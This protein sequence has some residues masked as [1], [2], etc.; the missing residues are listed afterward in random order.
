MSHVVDGVREYDIA[1][2]GLE[3]VHSAAV[4]VGAGRP[5]KARKQIE[6]NAARLL[7]VAW[8]TELAAR[9]GDQLD[10]PGLRQATLQTLPVQAYYAVFSAARAFT[11]VGGNEVSGHAG[12]HNAYATQHIRRAGLA[13]GTTL[14]GDPK[15]P[16]TCTLTPPICEPTAFNPIQAGHPPAD[17][18][19]A[20]LRMARKW[21]YETRRDSWL[22]DP[23]HRTKRGLPYTRLPAGARAEILG[24]LRCTT[25]LDFMYELRCSTNYRSIDEYSAE[26][27]DEHVVAFHGGL[28]HLMDMGLLT[29]EAQVSLYSGS[30]ALK[31]EYLDWSKRV[32]NVGSWA[33]EAGEA[34]IAAIEAG[35][36]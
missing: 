31:N 27:E 4:R 25:M 26:V 1:T 8:Q 3:S 5:F 21:K 17:L 24:S 36:L 18:V 13:M 30:K 6:P 19:W 33:S 28:L 29:Y 35:G 16:D 15:N 11:I 7:R 22:A 20:A 32:A 34:R 10:D 12:I 14:T 23:T 2:A 9:L